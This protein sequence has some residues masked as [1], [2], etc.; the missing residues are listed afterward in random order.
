VDAGEQRSALLAIR[1]GSQAWEDV[2]RWRL[3][4]H[5]EFEQAFRETKLPET[6]DYDGANRL[7]IWARRLMVEGRDDS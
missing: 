5:E 7:L 1:D 2:N 3:A 4:L 6:P